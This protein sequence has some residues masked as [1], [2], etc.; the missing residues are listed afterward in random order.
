MDAIANAIAAV[1]AFAFA[2]AAPARPAR[3]PM[4]AYEPMEP[5]RLFVDLSDDITP[6]NTPTIRDQRVYNNAERVA[7]R[8]RRE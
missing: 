7:K 5:R 6:P 4:H 8:Q 1:N 3:E 2:L